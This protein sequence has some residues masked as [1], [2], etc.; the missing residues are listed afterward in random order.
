MASNTAAVRPAARSNRRGPRGKHWVF[1]WNNYPANYKTIIS[2]TLELDSVNVAYGVFGEEVGDS[3]TPHIQGYIC[4]VDRISNPARR[5]WQAHWELARSPARAIEYCK[6]DG[7]FWEYGSQP[8]THQGKRSDIEAFKK[9]V[10][11]A[12]GEYTYRQAL[13]DHSALCARSDAFVEKFILA[14]VPD[15][16][17][18]NHPLR[19]W[20]ADLNRRLNGPTDARTVIWVYDSV[21]NTGKSWFCHYYKQNHPKTTQVLLP[22]DRKTMSYWVERNLRVY[23]IDLARAN[24]NKIS[25][26]FI[27]ELKNGFVG[28]EKY[29][30]H[31]KPGEYPHIVLMSNWLPSMEGDSLSLDRFS[32]IQVGS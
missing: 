1:T 4:C 27:E 18:E 26:A 16:K 21:G 6:K 14:N 25:W 19:V 17:V 22:R 3:G 10:M 23:F 2:D 15:K 24:E 28:S 11:D 32:I 30:C 7:E 31:M 8:Q 29:F 12:G 20:Q 13:F 5:L 9:D